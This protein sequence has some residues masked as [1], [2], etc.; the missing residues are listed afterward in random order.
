MATM[1]EELRKLIA[2]KKLVLGGDRCLDLAR[3]GKLAKAYLASNCAAATRDALQKHAALSGFEILEL[4]WTREEL[5]TLCGKPF[6]LAV[7]GVM[8]A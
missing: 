3:Q 6:P 5:G 4:P 8:K 2:A 7:A 1:S